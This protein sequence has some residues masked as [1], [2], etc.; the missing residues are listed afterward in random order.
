MPVWVRDGQGDC[1]RFPLAA[2]MARE[3]S[4]GGQRPRVAGNPTR[5]RLLTADV[6][7][8][9][10]GGSLRYGARRAA[11]QLAGMASWVSVDAVGATVWDI[12]GTLSS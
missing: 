4:R 11:R 8:I 3:L 10:T 1:R 12:I 7:E 6:D 2:A 5:A 9:A